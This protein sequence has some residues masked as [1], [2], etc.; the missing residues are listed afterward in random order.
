MTCVL[1]VLLH[2][3]NSELRPV[4]PYT[5]QTHAHYNAHLVSVTLTNHCCTECAVVSLSALVTR[6]P[7]TLA[8]QQTTSVLLSTWTL[9][10]PSFL[11]LSS[12]FTP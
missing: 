6:S 1:P 7:Y 3:T 4:V 10:G 5:L 9:Y 12:S 8:H 2:A 11:S